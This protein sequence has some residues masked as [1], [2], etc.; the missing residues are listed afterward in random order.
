MLD[1]RAWARRMHQLGVAPPP[2]ARRKLSVERLH[3]S[4][5]TAVTDLGMRE[6]AIAL[7]E[8][9]RAEDGVARALEVFERRIAPIADKSPATVMND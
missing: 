8:Q 5:A 1:Q 4:I 7:G 2:I 9:I 6:R 3:E